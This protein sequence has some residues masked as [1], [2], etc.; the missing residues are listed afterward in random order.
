MYKYFQCEYS[1]RPFTQIEIFNMQTSTLAWILIK[2]FLSSQGIASCYY[3][4]DLLP[5]LSLIL[6]QAALA[7][8]AYWED[9][10]HIST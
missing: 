5:L 8:A 10:L 6:E 7:N 9:A 3:P 2:F 1:F 4:A